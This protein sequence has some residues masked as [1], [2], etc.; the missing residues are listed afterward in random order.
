MSSKNR[1]SDKNNFPADLLEVEITESIIIEEGKEITES[2][3]KLR[4]N[5]TQIALD[6]FGTGY[7]SLSYLRK[8]PIST[9]KI[10]KS[11]IQDISCDKD[12]KLLTQAIVS[13][14][15]TLGLKVVA[16]GVETKEQLSVLRELGCDLIQGYYFAIPMNAEDLFSFIS[17]D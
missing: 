7:S 1:L 17:S 8:F 4:Q 10:D 14:A 12:A 15:K 9:L 3:E 13:L 6:D 2:L 11:F 16:E 5:G